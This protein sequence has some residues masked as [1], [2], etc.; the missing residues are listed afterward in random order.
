MVVASGIGAFAS[1]PVAAAA[2]T[3]LFA[4][5]GGVDISI[6]AVLAAMVGVHT[7]IGVG[8]ALVT[9]A[10]VSSVVSV[11]PDLVVGAS[12]LARPTTLVRP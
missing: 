6:G 9:M 8:E 7:V 5:G 12:D 2:F 11:R 1:V 3:L 10:V 4:L